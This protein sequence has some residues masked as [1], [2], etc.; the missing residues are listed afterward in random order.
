MTQLAQQAIDDI[1]QRGRIYEVGGTVRDRLLGRN[2]S[3]PDRDYLVT[4][5]PYNDLTKI[6]KSHGQVNLVGKSFGVI[7]FTQFVE[8][9][10]QTFDITLPR[11]EHST[12]VGHKDFDVAFDPFLKIEEDLSRRDFTVNAMALALDS[13]E[14]ID[15]L[16]GRLDLKKRQ[17]RIAYDKSFEDDPL[18]MLRAVQFA[19]RLEFT[20]EPKTFDMMCRHAPLI[21][22]VSSER[23]AEELNKLLVLAKKPSLGFNLMKSSGLLKEILPELEE[24][25]G[26]D[27]PGGF[28]RYNVF[29]HTLHTIDACQPSLRL[30]LAALFHD[31]NKPQHKRVVEDGANFYGHE[32]TGTKTARKVM[33]RLRYSNDLIDEVALLVERH[34][35]TTNVTD[36]GLR[37][38]LRKVGVDLIFD[39]LDLRRADVAAQG[40]GGTTEDV[41]LF[42]RQI[43]EELSRTPPLSVSDLALDGHDIM[44]MFNIKPGPTVG[45]IID[46]LLECVLDDPANNTSETLEVLAK[47][48]FEKNIKEE[49]DEN[50]ENNKS[51]DV[52]N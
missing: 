8:G 33:R 13:E 31:I 15:P 41:D 24:C 17:L 25:V 2:N 21:K 16:D 18:R 48:F 49:M 28:H 3:S 22:T 52:S 27:Q 19:A 10:A 50:V 7:K 44:K 30:R 1:L 37:R 14:L 34:M 23:I 38:L 35:F 20:V 47:D 32:L 4:G 11:R 9:A 42:E 46:Y 12:G 6:L 45:K 26:V 36:K 40:R 29:E 5:I 51:N 39:L 43:R